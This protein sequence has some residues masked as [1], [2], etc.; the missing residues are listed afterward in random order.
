MAI[1]ILLIYLLTSTQ[2]DD[3]EMPDLEN[4]DKAGEE[5][6]DASKPKIEEVQ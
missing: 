2:S 4:E 1:Q 6:T 5:K 3:E